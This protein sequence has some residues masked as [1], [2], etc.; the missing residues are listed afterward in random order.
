[1]K[2]TEFGLV[3]ISDICVESDGF[4]NVRHQL[5]DVAELAC[6]IADN[7]LYSALVLW[8]SPTGNL[9]LID[10]HRRLAAIQMLV[11]TAGG[12]D[13]TGFAEIACCIVDGS[14]EQAMAK[15]L[16]LAIHGA[17]LNPADAMERAAYLYS[18]WGNQAEV[19]SS[20][21]KSQS[22]VSYNLRIFNN[23]IPAALEALRNELINLSQ[24]DQLA[25]VLLED[26]TKD[27]EKQDEL[28][29][30]MLTGKKPKKPKEI[31]PKTKRTKGE[32]TEMYELAIKARDAH[33]IDSH[34]P[35]TII[36]VLEWYRCKLDVPEVFTSESLQIDDEA[37]L[38]GL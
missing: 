4:K 32:V 24:A 36:R 37:I 6:D 38:A 9:V 14:L 13:A 25:D 5:D 28:L 34:V 31:K 15:N 33:D 23:I 16:E 30:Q 27:I 29:K 35:E 17:S 11:D 26:G 3:S 7:G 19:A 12:L 1:M 2:Q 21:G 10:G 18:T 8:R 22:W 20:V